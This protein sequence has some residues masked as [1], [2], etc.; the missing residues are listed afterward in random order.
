M[1]KI[2]DVLVYKRNVCKIV[3]IKDKVFNNL[4][5][6]VLIPV[7][8]KSLKIEIPTNN[9]SIRSLITKKQ[10]KEIIDKIPEIEKIE[11]VDSK[12][13]SVESKYRELLNSENYEDLISI[14]KTAHLKNLERL[15][16]K[17]PLG[18]LDN[19]FSRLADQYLYNEF[20]AVLGLSYEDTK[21][22]IVDIINK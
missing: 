15:E 17:K 6:Y 16:N 7:Y 12:Y 14:I 11:N 21:K 18:N 1:F 8:D 4:D 20:A 10:A 3:D 5:Y 22:Y 9:I 2:G 19:N 13:K